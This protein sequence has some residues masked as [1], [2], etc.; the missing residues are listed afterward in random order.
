MLQIEFPPLRWNLL[1]LAAA[2]QDSFSEAVVSRLWEK[3]MSIAFPS[4]KKERTL[5]SWV[6]QSFLPELD[7]RLGAH[8]HGTK[9]EAR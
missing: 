2:A 8:L 3:V 5:L 6:P 4:A 1:S 9:G 7:W